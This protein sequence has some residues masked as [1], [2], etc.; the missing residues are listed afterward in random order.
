MIDILLLVSDAFVLG[1]VHDGWP[2]L[3]LPPPPP[4]LLLVD[5]FDEAAHLH[6]GILEN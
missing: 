3:M 5:F 1:H 2:L 4:L 6:P